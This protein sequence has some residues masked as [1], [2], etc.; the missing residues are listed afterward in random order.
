MAPFNVQHPIPGK[1]SGRTREGHVARMGNG[2]ACEACH[3]LHNLVARN[4][5]EKGALRALQ[6]G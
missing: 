1:N 5:E 4:M 2:Y 6:S 3:Y